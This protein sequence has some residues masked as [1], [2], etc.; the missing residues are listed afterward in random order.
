MANKKSRKSNKKQN[1][2]LRNKVDIKGGVWEYSKEGEGIII[3]VPIKSEIDLP[4][5]IAIKKKLDEWVGGQVLAFT[6]SVHEKYDQLI[7][8]SDSSQVLNEETRELI[9]G[10]I[11]YLKNEPYG[12]KGA[13]TIHDGVI[14]EYERLMK[15]EEAKGKRAVENKIRTVEENSRA[16]EEE[17]YWED[18]GELSYGGQISQRKSQKSQNKKSK[19]KSNKKHN[20]RNG[21]NGGNS[22][23]KEENV[24]PIVDMDPNQAHM[25]DFYKRKE[26]EEERKR[27]EEEEKNRFSNMSLAE[28]EEQCKKGTFGNLTAKCIKTQCRGLTNGGQIS[29]RKS[30]KSQNKKSKRKSN[31]KHNKRNGVKGGDNNSEIGRVPQKIVVPNYYSSYYNTQAEDYSKKKSDKPTEGEIRLTAVQINYDFFEDWNKLNFDDEFEIDYV[32]NLYLYK[33]SEHLSEYLKN[34]IDLI[35]KAVQSV[36]AEEMPENFQNLKDGEK[37]PKPKKP[38]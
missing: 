14:E 2:R 10:E 12:K 9:I 27:A 15:S 23:N 34:D 5:K 33:Y 22:N 7:F 1:K 21:G 26:E 37:F 3:K 28:C 8:F 31:K 6:K 25:N 30:Q 29:Q 38:Y 20:K 16:A 24:A 19:R 32:L 4:T 17:K 18:R 11:K 36:L 13:K 35:D